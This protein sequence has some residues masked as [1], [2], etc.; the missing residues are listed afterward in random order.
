MELN[1][2][3]KRILNKIIFE[4]LT[5]LNYLNEKEENINL[6]ETKIFNRYYNRF[7]NL[8]H[9]DIDSLLINKIILNDDMIKLTINENKHI[10]IYEDLIDD[11]EIIIIEDI[12]INI[13]DIYDKIGEENEIINKIKEFKNKIKKIIEI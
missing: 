8:L 2:I 13:Y 12:M 6:I 4:Y 1:K 11:F 10:I 7:N 3:N 5:Y 9:N